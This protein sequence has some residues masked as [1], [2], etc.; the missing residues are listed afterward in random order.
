MSSSIGGGDKDKEGIEEEEQSLPSHSWAR[1]QLSNL[2][3]VPMPD[4]RTSHLMPSLLIPL[5]TVFPFHKALYI[6]KVHG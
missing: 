6:R 4:H 2:T 3:P 1:K 5:L